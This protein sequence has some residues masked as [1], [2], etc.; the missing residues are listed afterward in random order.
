MLT[1][2][3][4]SEPI[5][6]LLTDDE[7]Y[8]NVVWAILEFHKKFEV[9]E[10]LPL[11]VDLLA[12][13][14][15]EFMEEILMTGVSSNLLKETSDVIYILEGLLAMI[16]E[17]E[18]DLEWKTEEKLDNT[19]YTINRYIIPLATTLFT[20]NQIYSA[21]LET[22]RSNMSKLDADGNVIRREDGKVLK[23]DQYSKADVSKIHHPQRMLATFESIIHEL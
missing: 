4:L 22:H 17:E 8:T 1:R 6:K 12:E 21:V 19:L 15:L 20:Q 10:N 5:R 23:S 16:D 13:E 14:A 18:L 9:K 11:Y 2:N 3:E 7:A